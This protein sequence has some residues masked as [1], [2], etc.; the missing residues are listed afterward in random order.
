VLVLIEP[1]TPDGFKRILLARQHLLRAGAVVVAPCTH[2]AVCPLAGA[3]WCHFKERVQRSRAHMHAKSASVP[4]E[5][6][7]FSY[8]VVA[9]DGAVSGGARVLAPVEVSKIA[10][11]MK[12]CSEQGLSA[13]N[14]PSRDK[15]NYKR[16]KK[17]GWG[18]LWQG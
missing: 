15:T 3:D 14:V 18:D 8:L 5:D 7:A 2:H 9:R 12:L 10:V 1:G 13:A 11:T 6:E 17:A 4:F 16:A